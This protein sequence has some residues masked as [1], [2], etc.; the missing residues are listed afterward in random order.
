MTKTKQMKVGTKLLLGFMVVAIIA[1]VV[2]VVGLINLNSVGNAAAFIIE[3]EFP[4]AEAVLEAIIASLKCEVL[5]EQFLVAEDEEEFILIE[6]QYLKAVDDM[7]NNLTFIKENS[8]GEIL[9]LMDELKEYNKEFEEDAVLLMEY[10]R[11][12][13]ADE[14][15]AHEQLLEVENLTIQMNDELESY[16]ESITRTENIST[17]LEASMETKGIIAEQEAIIEK[18][19]GLRSL[20]DTAVLRDRLQVLDEEFNEYSHFIPERIVDEHKE[21]LEHT[22]ILFDDIDEAI[23]SE[24]E[25][26]HE[27][28]LIVEL[29]EKGDL[30][31]IKAEEL[32]KAIM[33]EAIQNADNTQSMAFIIMIALTVIGFIIAIALGFIIAQGITKPLGGEPGEMAE[34]AASIAGGDL[35]VSFDNK[36]YDDQSVYAAM[37]SMT[38]N[39]V[40]IMTNVKSAAGNVS[41]GSQ[42]LSSSAQQMSQGSTEQ[43]ASTE[44]VSSSMEEMGSN[45]RQNADNAM[46]TEKIS[47]KAAQDAS[48]SGTAVSSAV[49]AMKEIATKISIIEEIARQTNLLA[50]NAAIEAARA[51]EHGKGFAVV[52]S[53]V[54]KLA[55]RSQTAAGEISELSSTSVDVAEKAGQMLLKLVPDI[56]KTAELVQEISAA[57]REQNNGVEQINRAI[58]QLDQVV[59]Q[60]ASASEEVA[61][62]SE[63][64]SSQAEQLQAAI[65]FFKTKSNGNGSSNIRER[66]LIGAGPTKLSKKKK[67]IV[68]HINKTGSS[69]VNVKEKPEIKTNAD[70]TINMEDSQ[71]KDSLDE[72]FEEY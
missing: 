52:A 20:E 40:D 54:R 61:S 34:I 57:S 24:L 38:E 56:K 1:G 47:T 59:Q 67:H 49:G 2:G 27:M 28:E 46:E 19:A 6:E 5:L 16:K 48:E 32:T 53:E 65:E 71:H 21:L 12:Y 35:T 45:I 72:N 62:T 7:E 31:L 8:E 9:I 29:I 15:E 66:A 3:E 37:K 69:A 68:G 39:L 36:K 51:G 64:L 41:S 60:N 22:L 25:A 55:E 70:K 63:E 11:T 58:L 26:N 50:L 17:Q 23:K 4:I 42:E 30:D 14:I 33:S 43:A 10:H 13:V 18:Y 44:E